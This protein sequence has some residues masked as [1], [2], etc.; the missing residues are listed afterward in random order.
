MIPSD[1]VQSSSVN[2]TNLLFNSELSSSK[3]RHES[4]ALRGAFLNL[5]VPVFLNKRIF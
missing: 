5:Q 1:T 3:F 2:Q 4:I